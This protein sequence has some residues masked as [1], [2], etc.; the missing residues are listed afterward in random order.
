M[1]WSRRCCQPR[2]AP[3]PTHRS[4]G[5][6]TRHIGTHHPGDTG[7]D[8]EGALA[9]A[10]TKLD[11]A[12]GDHQRLVVDLDAPALLAPMRDALDRNE[13]IEIEYYSA[14]SD[15]NTEREIDPY[16]VISLDGT[17]TSTPCASGPG[18]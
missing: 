16:R 9:G 18:M 5:I 17:G 15:T 6:R 10:L 3:P 12:L 1:T 13:R 14:S 4:R 11:A 2:W 8:R 7:A